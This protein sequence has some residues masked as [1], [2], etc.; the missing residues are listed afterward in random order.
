MNVL[1]HENTGL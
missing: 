1:Y